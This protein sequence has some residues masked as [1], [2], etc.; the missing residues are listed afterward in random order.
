MFQIKIKSFMIGITS[1]LLFSCLQEDEF[2]IPAV[3][4]TTPNI[5]GS[6]ISIHALED[7]LLQEMINNGNNVLTFN[8]DLFVSG[9][10][11]SNDEYGNFFKEIII[12]NQSSEATKGLKLKIDASPLFQSY[13]FG[14]KVYVNLNGLTVGYDSGLLSLGWRDGNRISPISESQMFNFV[15]RDTIVADIVPTQFNLSDLNNTLLN[16]YVRLDD[17]QFNRNEVLGDNPLTFAGEP[18]DEFDGE[19]TLESC[20]ENYSIIFSTSTFADF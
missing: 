17:V 19:R 5:S 8:S 15:V 9:F 13:Q 4:E 7:A 20:L 16:T 1:I 18:D 12:Q 6:E 14:R 3:Q 10:V 2:D 11:I